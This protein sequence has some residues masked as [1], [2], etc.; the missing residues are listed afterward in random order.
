MLNTDASYT[1]AQYLSMGLG[2]DLGSG[3]S[4]EG[5]VKANT[6]DRNGEQIG[7]VSYGI[8]VGINTY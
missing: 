3:M 6:V 1:N 5:S 7:T 2:M 8:A 4:V